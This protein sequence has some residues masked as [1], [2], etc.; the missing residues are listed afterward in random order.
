[1]AGSRLL[2]QEPVFDTFIGKL[3]QR[4]RTLRVGP[5]LDKVMDMGGLVDPSH[6]KDIAKYVDEARQ[7]GA[8]VRALCVLFFKCL[9]SEAGVG[10]MPQFFFLFK[11][12]VHICDIS[13]LPINFLISR[14]I[15]VLL[16]EMVRRLAL[17]LN[18]LWC[19]YV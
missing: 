10:L 18:L 9:L 1:M 6:V 7:E 3:K 16:N 8:E 5:S 2:V 4:M 17:N 19:K 15:G 13:I 11:F 14:K 12:F